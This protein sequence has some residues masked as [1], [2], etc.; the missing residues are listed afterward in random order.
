MLSECFDRN[1]VVASLFCVGFGTIGLLAALRV[2]K[3]QAAGS[4]RRMSWF[5]LKDL[6]NTFRFVVQDAYLLM[7]VL[8]S[9][10]FLLIAGFMQMNIL[11]YGMQVFGYTQEHSA[12]LFLFAAIGIGIG[13]LAAG[14][15]SGRKH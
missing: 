4:D 3:T 1:F 14:K 5:F 10:Y 7:A 11:P 2:E 6:W 12:Y 9:A 15:L 8:A 13:S